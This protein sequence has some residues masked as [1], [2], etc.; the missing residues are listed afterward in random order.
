MEKST[1]IGFCQ[2]F[3]SFFTRNGT[4]YLLW[5]LENHV[6][7]I[8]Y[9][10]WKSK[11]RKDDHSWAVA[12]KTGLFSRVIWYISEVKFTLFSIYFTRTFDPDREK[13]GSGGCSL[14]TE[15]PGVENR[16][17]IGCCAAGREPYIYNVLPSKKMESHGCSTLPRLISRLPRYAF[18]PLSPKNIT[19]FSFL[20]IQRNI[21]CSISFESFWRAEKEYWE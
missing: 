7:R 1:P 15:G 8:K 18:L 21:S 11:G 14:L 5:S 6:G 20:N 9:S 3:S 17:Q 10:T 16:I 12:S 19:Y 4:I 13:M 2:Q